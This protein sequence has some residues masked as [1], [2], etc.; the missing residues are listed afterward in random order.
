[1]FINLNLN[2]IGKV[3]SV[4]GFGD[5]VEKMKSVWADLKGQTV[6]VNWT[7][8]VQFLSKCIDDLV[9]YLVEQKI[10]GEDKKATVIDAIG[11]IYDK[12]AAAVLPFWLK[13]VSFLI[14]RFV[15]NVLISHAIDMIVSKYNNGSW[16]PVATTEVL[17]LWGVPGG[18]RPN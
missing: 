7:I 3:A 9:V 15:I 4:P 6:G 2:P 8:A 14:R 18:H 16:S 13:P 17:N 10:P 11:G 5:L 1:M 12:V